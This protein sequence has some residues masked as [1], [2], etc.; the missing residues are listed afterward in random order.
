MMD[1]VMGF[2]IGQHV[3]HMANLDPSSPEKKDIA[4]DLLTLVGSSN[5]I[6]QEKKVL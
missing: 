6:F 5:V 1:D 2:V 3:V 4:L